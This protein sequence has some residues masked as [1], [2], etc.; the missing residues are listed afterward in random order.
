MT[1]RI[2]KTVFVPLEHVNGKWVKRDDLPRFLEPEQAAQYLLDNNAISYR[3][4]KP[5][6]LQWQER[7]EWELI[8]EYLRGVGTPEWLSIQEYKT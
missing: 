6:F 3:D 8:N 2:P 5:V 1:L 7:H 4:G